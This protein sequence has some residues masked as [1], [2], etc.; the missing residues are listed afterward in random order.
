MLIAV[1]DACVLIDL[2]NGG[3]VARWFQLRIETHT[4]D[5]VLYELEDEAQF[6]E[7]KRFVDAGLIKVAPMYEGDKFEAIQAVANM[8][9]EMGVSPPDASAFLLAQKLEAVLLTGDGDLRKQATARGITV[10]GVL[11]VLDMLVWNDVIDF[12]MASDSLRE[13]LEKGARLPEGECDRRSQ[14]WKEERKIR[15]REV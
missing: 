8:A 9:E 15:P 11:W 14:A 5:A 7:V 2:A 10:F 12:Q 1:K 3:L 13:M 6:F 4:T